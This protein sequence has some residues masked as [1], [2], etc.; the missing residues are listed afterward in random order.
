[1]Y[2]SFSPSPPSTSYSTA[3]MEIP[4][5][6]RSR[7]QSPSCAYPS[8]PRRASLSSNSSDEDHQSSSFIIS[9]EELFPDVFDDAEQDCT[10][11]ATPHSGRSPASPSMLCDMVVESGSLMRQLMA[12]EK[13][14]RERRRRKSSASKKSR[15]GSGA[16]K[17]MSP[18]LEVGE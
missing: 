2:F 1:M 13:A 16:S 7:P 15:S 4:S 5:S 18:I 9:D 6:S 8:W 12:E 17:H 14:K 3:P 11:P 10:P